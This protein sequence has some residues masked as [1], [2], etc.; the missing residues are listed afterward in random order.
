[1]LINKSY[2]VINP[3]QIQIMKDLG[4]IFD[5]EYLVSPKGFI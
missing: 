2:S 1:M 3:K 4:V 5:V